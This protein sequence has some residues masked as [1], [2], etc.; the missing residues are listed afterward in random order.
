MKV[1]LDRFLPTDPT[2]VA[3]R[4]GADVVAPAKTATVKTTVAQP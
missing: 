1:L 4:P 2:A 3:K